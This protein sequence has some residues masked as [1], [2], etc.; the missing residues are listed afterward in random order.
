MSNGVIILSPVVVNS[1][2]LLVSDKNR[3]TVG[4]KNSDKCGR[5]ENAIKGSFGGEE[6]E[7]KRR[8][9]VVNYC[10]TA[11]GSGGN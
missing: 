10:H 2:K 8:K 5:Q 3:L 1:K 4:D 6:E 11:T 7:L 9:S